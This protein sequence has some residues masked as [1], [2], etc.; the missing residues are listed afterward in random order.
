M[1]GKPILDAIYLSK[2]LLQEK[3]GEKKRQLYFVF[4]DSEKGFD[5]VP[6]DALRWVLQRQGVPE[7]L[8]NLAMAL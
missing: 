2:L 6:R 8:T 1:P 7:W 4:V 3:Y 5:K